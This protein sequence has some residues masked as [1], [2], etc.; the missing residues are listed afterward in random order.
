MGIISSNQP[1]CIT[2]N[3]IFKFQIEIE[4]QLNLECCLHVQHIRPISSCR[5]SHLVFILHYK[6]SHIQLKYTHLFKN[7]NPMRTTYLICCS[8]EVA[9]PCLSWMD[10]NL[11]LECFEGHDLLALSIG[12][13]LCVNF[14]VSIRANFLT[15]LRSHLDVTCSYYFWSSL[16]N[17]DDESLH[18]LDK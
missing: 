4:M 14:Y 13:R 11:Q 3:V 6:P 10:F 9:E 2:K 15:T 12:Q 8:L 16:F 5:M 18:T 1:L 17:V 7:R